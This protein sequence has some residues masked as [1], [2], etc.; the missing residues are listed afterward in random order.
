M[1]QQ[2]MTPESRFWQWFAENESSLFE[3]PPEAFKAR[4]NRRLRV[5]CPGLGC[6]RE[7]GPDGR[8]S[9]ILTAHGV[10]Q[11]FPFVEA[12]AASAPDLAHFRVVAFAPAHPG[13]VPSQDVRFQRMSDGEGTGV[14]LFVRNYSEDRQDVVAKQMSSLLSALLG[15][16]DM[17]TKVGFVEVKAMPA[18]AESLPKLEKLPLAL[19]S[20]PHDR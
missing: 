20:F 5:V 13:D 9:L 11:Y 3:A 18:E 7:T 6:D 15:E 10:L 16:Y 4:V 17:E 14:T 8:C 2:L 19:G 1:D 12:L